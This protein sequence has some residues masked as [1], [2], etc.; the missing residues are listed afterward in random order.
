VHESPCFH[1]SRHRLK[2]IHLV[3]TTEVRTR[4]V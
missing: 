2:V 1:I 3:I 4:R